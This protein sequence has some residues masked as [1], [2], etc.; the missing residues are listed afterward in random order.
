MVDADISGSEAEAGMGSGFFSPRSLTGE[1]QLARYYRA[2]EA[3]IIPEAKFTASHFAPAVLP[4]RPELAATWERLA[5]VLYKAFRSIVSHYFEDERIRAIYD[6]PDAFEKILA[7]LHGLPYA[8]GAVRPDFLLERGTRAPKICETGARYPLNGWLASYLANHALEAALTMQNSVAVTPDLEQRGFIQ[9]IRDHFDRDDRVLLVH[10]REPGTEIFL[11]LQYLEDLGL[12]SEEATPAELHLEKG[13]ATVRGEGYSQF[14]LE[15]DRSELPGFDPDL[16]RAMVRDGIC[17]NDPRTLILIHDKRVLAVLGDRDIMAAYL[18][19]DEI[20]FLS[21][22][23]IPSFPLDEDRLEAVLADDGDWVFK[24][25]SG[26]RSVDA[27][28]KSE[29]TGDALR[30]R[31]ASELPQYMVQRRVEQEV[32]DTADP[33]VYVGLLLFFNGRSF[34]TGVYRCGTDRF[35]CAGKGARVVPSGFCDRTR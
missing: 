35:V 27:F 13:K 32:F 9:C 21:D 1:A 30:G 18:T 10:D 28:M 29:M 11:F 3:R 20:D 25:N 12:T 33:A 26:G 2:L 31:L 24:K 7:R 19:P 17:L 34:G 15:M 14:I 5:A 8:V 22:F 16:L 23:L 6:L 4:Q